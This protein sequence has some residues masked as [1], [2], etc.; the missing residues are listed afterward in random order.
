MSCLILTFWCSSL[1]SGIFVLGVGHT[2]QTSKRMISWRNH[3]SA[4]WPTR[5]SRSKV[6]GRQVCHLCPISPVSVNVDISRLSR[7]RTALLL[8]GFAKAVDAAYPSFSG[9][10]CGCRFGSAFFLPPSTQQLFAE[11]KIFVL[12]E[13]PGR[14]GCTS[15]SA[16]RTASF[17]APRRLEAQD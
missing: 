13:F 10:A 12:T 2:V 16:N 6:F 9:G 14:S 3:L 8:K 4:N 11:N 17:S 7:C 5:R 15:P 1:G